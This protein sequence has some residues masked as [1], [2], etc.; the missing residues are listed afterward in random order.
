VP[1]VDLLQGPERVVALRRIASLDTIIARPD[2]L[3]AAWAE[4]CRSRRRYYLSALQCLTRPESWLFD[5]GALPTTSLRLTPGHVA[6]LRNLFSCESH[7][8][9]CT[10]LLS[11]MLDEHV[12]EV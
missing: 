8:D 5:H 4:F 1:R 2:R 6:R 11:G 10:E 12:R 3:H 7:H 9:A